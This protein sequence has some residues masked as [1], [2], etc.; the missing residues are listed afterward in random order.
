MPR[1]ADTFKTLKNSGKKAFIAYITAGDPSLKITHDLVLELEK[2]GVDIIELGIPFS[3]PLADGVTIQ[4]AMQRAL[5]SDVS[6]SEVLSLVAK[7]RKK[8]QIPLIFMS[9]Y[10]LIFNYGLVKFFQAAAKAGLD[11]VIVPDLPPEEADEL[12]KAAAS[13]KMDA[14]FLVAPT[15]S[16]ARIKE[17]VAGSTG[18][19]YL[20]SVAGIT[21]ARGEIELEGVNPSTLLGASGQVARV[22]K[23]TDLPVC[24]G[25][26][27]SNPKQAREM[28]EV[29]DGVI[30]G[31][32]IVKK[33][34]ENLGKKD[35][36]AGVGRF[37]R[38]MVG[39]IKE[40]A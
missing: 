30:V 8:S 4:R 25:F 13:Y 17:I 9:A 26:G 21:G 39:A 40:E 24:I 1:L 12:Q 28:A 18:F 33:I 6:V 2:S 19:V 22:K 5:K 31:S 29:A 20:V 27:I 7:L 10:N 3:D 34:E 14:I 23:N 32:A 11:G 16:D 35:L 36:V 37:V 38:Q 15:S